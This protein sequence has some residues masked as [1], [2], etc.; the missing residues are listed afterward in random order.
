MRK[1]TTRDLTL[2]AM[3][4]ALY[5][6]LCYF[7]TIFQ[8]TFGP[9]QVRL[10]EALTVLPFLFPATAP[11]LA[12]GCLLTNILSP[13]GPIDMAVGTLATAIAAFW[14]MKMPRWYLAGLPP[15]V[16]NALLLPPMWAWAEVG[17]L[18]GAFWAAYGL[19]LW[20]FVAGE[21]V[22][23]YVLGTVL[24]LALP[25]VRYFRSMIPE[26]RLAHL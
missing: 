13:Y 26:C 9:V 8:L 6:V 12:V 7:G 20:T 3:V 18:N 5:F 23:C 14:T 19:N 17:A 16:M 25:R 21:A 22:A 11:G 15:V 10:G 1:F 2:S 4:A 24:V